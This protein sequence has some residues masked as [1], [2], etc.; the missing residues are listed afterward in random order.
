MEPISLTAAVVQDV[1][2]ALIVLQR[3]GFFCD[4]ERSSTEFDLCEV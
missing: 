2:V 4:E 3:F 1:Q